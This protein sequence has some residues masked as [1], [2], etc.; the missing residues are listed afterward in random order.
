MYVIWYYEHWKYFVCD[1]Y[2]NKLLD[3]RYIHNVKSPCILKSNIMYPKAYVYMK[4]G[5]L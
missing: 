5:R 3:N 1:Y 4:N 2:T